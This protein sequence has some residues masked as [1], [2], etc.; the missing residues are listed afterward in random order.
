MISIYELL[1]EVRPSTIIPNPHKKTFILNV[2][3]H[4]HDLNLTAAYGYPVAIV[5]Y[6]S[7]PYFEFIKIYGLE[8]ITCLETIT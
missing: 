3:G 7:R 2:N 6:E 8:T 4:L 1:V 5:C